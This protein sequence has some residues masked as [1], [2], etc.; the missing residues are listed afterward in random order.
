ML[1]T[2]SRIAQQLE[3]DGH[4]ELAGEADDIITAIAN[5]DSW[6]RA[7]EG[8][9]WSEELGEQDPSETIG[10]EEGLRIQEDPS[11]LGLEASDTYSAVLEDH[12]D[13]FSRYI[14]QHD[15][16]RHLIESRRSVHTKTVPNS[17]IEE[18]IEEL[19]AIF[20]ELAARGG[21][22]VKP[23]YEFDEAAR[24]LIEETALV[25]M[26]DVA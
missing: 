2:L 16:T 20:D 9:L 25:A 13:A 11:G 12:R 15:L 26:V 3:N 6:S 4:H 17:Y 23:D 5:R 1:S 8:D 19:R 24:R 21:R 7:E 14:A 22:H 10:E 18:M